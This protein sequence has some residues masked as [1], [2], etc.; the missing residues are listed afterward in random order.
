MGDAMG[1]LQLGVLASY[2]GDYLQALYH[3]L[4]SLA[5][6]MPFPTARANAKLLFDKVLTLCANLRHTS[7]TFLM[8]NYNRCLLLQS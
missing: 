4:Y 6:P 8:S 3:C 1:V 2:A 7:L 5:V